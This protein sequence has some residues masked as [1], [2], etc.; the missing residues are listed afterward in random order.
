[1]AFGVPG[2]DLRALN[3]AGKCYSLEIHPQPY[4]I[5]KIIFYFLSYYIQFPD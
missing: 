1:M 5:L 4:S 2:I 3:I